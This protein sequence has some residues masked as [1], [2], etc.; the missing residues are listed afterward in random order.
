MNPKV[1]DFLDRKEDLTMVGLYW[2]LYWRFI[3]VIW[4]TLF[5]IMIV[6]SGITNLFF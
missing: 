1:K 6:I 4:G 3:V 5:I 2:A